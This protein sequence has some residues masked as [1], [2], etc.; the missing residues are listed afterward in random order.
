MLTIGTKKS[1]IKIKKLDKSKSYYF[2]IDAIKDDSN[3]RKSSARS[4]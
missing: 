2:K 3:V 4:K 1:K